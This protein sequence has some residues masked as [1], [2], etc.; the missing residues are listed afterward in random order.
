MKL[1]A[2][3]LLCCTVVAA[4]PPII[5]DTDAGSDDLMAIAYLL[6]SGADIEAITVVSGVAHV[7]PGAQNILRLLELAGKKI[8]VYEGQTATPPGGHA[9]PAAWR[10]AADHLTDVDFPPARRQS[11][12]QTAAEFLVARLDQTN[13]PVTILA[14]GPLTNLAA[15][16][17][18]YP[19]PIQ[20]IA[21]LVIM[22][23]A[24]R[25]PGN[26]EDAGE[27][28]SG[29]PHAEWNIFADPRA[30]QTV[31]AS[32]APMQLI[33]LDATNQVPIHLDYSAEFTRKATT[34]LGKVTAQI[35]ATSKGLMQSHIFFA[36]DP[37]AA[38]ALLHPDVVTFTPLALSVT[39]NGV[40]RE[41]AG[42]DRVQAA[43]SANSALFHQIFLEPFTAPR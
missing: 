3:M 12:S 25:V 24:V 1:L 10:K 13:K 18:Q 34:P 8:P 20:N 2:A 22:G 16:L 21:Q 26:V 38:V 15:A 19:Q 7:H 39:A 29:N 32:G 33:P 11:Q 36:W 42:A 28:Y 43:L 30:A 17:R 6:A 5:V 37:L 23:A 27:A 9:F 40:T 31:F 4:A 14:L 41:T 35:L